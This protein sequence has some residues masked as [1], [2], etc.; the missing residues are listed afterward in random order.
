MAAPSSLRPAAPFAAALLTSLAWGCSLVW[1]EEPAAETTAAAEAGGEAG[2][3]APADLPPL[4]LPERYQLIRFLAH[5]D[6]TYTAILT[7]P[8]GKGAEAVN[9]LQR[10]VPH[11]RTPAQ[12]EPPPPAEGQPAPPAPVVGRDVSSVEVVQGGGT[13]FLSALHPGNTAKAVVGSMDPVEDLLLVRGNDDQ[14]EDVLE[15]LDVWYNAAPQIEIQAAV[16]E[17]TNNDLFE[18][19]VVQAD[20]KPILQQ[21][22]PNVFLKSLGGQFPT[23]GNPN[24]VQ[25]VPQS[26]AGPGLGG[27]FKIGFV[28]SDFELNAYLQFLQ[29]NGVVDIISQP[30]VVT[31]N[32]IPAILSSTEKIPFL[33]PNS[34]TFSGTTTF[35]I[36]YND[37]GVTLNV[38]PFLIG[39]DTVHLVIQAE[40]SRLGREFVVGT[41]GVGNP[42]S[43]PSTTKRSATTDVFVRSG[44]KVVIGGLRVEESR[45]S[46]S[47]VPLLGDLPLLGWLFSNKSEQEIGAD[48]YFVITPVVKP[49]P[50]IDPIGDVFSPFE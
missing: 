27:V 49:V 7:V 6:G 8:N 24:F 12:L 13:A 2:E 5:E 14:I 42:I 30:R 4:T 40:V 1:E 45:I 35:N 22:S 38:V 25:N 36:Q 48:I 20:G 15:A 43:V 32:G 21:G 50:T 9:H 41:D 33:N 46:E 44:Q 17:V 3:T 19:G 47:K 29:Q 16:F 10:L 31:R 28:D 23:A 18:R 26:G 37:I 39:A 11:L 34:V